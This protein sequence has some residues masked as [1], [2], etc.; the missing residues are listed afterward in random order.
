MY[1]RKHLLLFLAPIALAAEA[2]TLP[3]T[4]AVT[5]TLTLVASGHTP[6]NSI[7]SQT[8]SSTW[9][10]IPT[11]PP[12]SLSTLTRTPSSHSTLLVKATNVVV[13]K[14]ASE[15]N[16]ATET[17]LAPASASAPAIGGATSRQIPGVVAAGAI[18]IG[19]FIMV[20]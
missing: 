15:T 18:A 5:M 16:K 4:S 1:L 7:P 19:G 9:Q 13:G 14:P 6:I 17:A 2:T 10:Q 8:P 11:S 3:S 20:L 12:N